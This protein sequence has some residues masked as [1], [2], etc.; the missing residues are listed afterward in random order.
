MLANLSRS[1]G[2]KVRRCLVG[3]L[4]AVLVLAA[5][6]ATAV[7]GYSGTVAVLAA[8]DNPDNCPDT[9]YFSFTGTS[10][11]YRIERSN[12]LYKEMVAL[13]MQAAI[14]GSIVTVHDTGRFACDGYPITDYV[15]AGL[16]PK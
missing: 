13:V 5:S 12:P 8:S 4:A 11:A 7:T 15:A 14:S 3:S 16:G 1:S 9:F 6:P 10:V 2:A